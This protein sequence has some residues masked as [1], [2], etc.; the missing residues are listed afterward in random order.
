L[1]DALPL[2]QR[3]SRINPIDPDARALESQ[4]LL[5]R[6]AAARDPADLPRAE[7]LAQKA[8]QLD[9]VTPGRWRHLGRV[10]LARGDLLGAYL[11]L[12]RAAALYPIRIE[13]REERNQLRDRIARSAGPG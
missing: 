4:I 8:V 11:A 6:A 3:A 1:E 12:A 10:R 5:E 9:P 7:A 2:V 13:Y